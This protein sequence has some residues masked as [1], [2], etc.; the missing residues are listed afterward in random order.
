MTTILPQCIY[1]KHLQPDKRTEDGRWR[2]KSFGTD[3]IPQEILLNQFD[4]R[5][6]HP[7]DAGLLYD[8]KPGSPE[9]PLGL[10]E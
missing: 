7:N 6:K 9:H 3:P 8:P 4:H 10:Q 5:H 1:C 2:C